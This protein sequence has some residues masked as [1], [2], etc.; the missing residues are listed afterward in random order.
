MNRRSDPE[1]TLNLDNT[2]RQQTLTMIPDGPTGT[3]VQVQVTGRTQD[4][5]D[6]VFSTLDLFAA[7]QK[8]CSHQVTGKQLLQD[9]LITSWP[10]KRT[11]PA[12][13]HH[14][15]SPDFGL[16]TAGTQHTAGMSGHGLHFAINGCDSVHMP[17][18]DII[19]RV[20]CTESI[21][22]GEHDVHIRSDHIGDQGTQGVVIT[23]TQFLDG[24]SVVFID[25]RH[26][27]ELEQCQD[28]IADIKIP[29]S[30]GKISMG[31]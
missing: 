14:F 13:S 29:V 16:H 17:G 18:R 22:I 28:S 20:C 3:T 30:V 11:S 19:N 8:K 4:I 7:G 2:G 6:P 9:F 21:H 25:N 15:C 23:K 24:N 27:P 26:N 10:D 1:S 31:E 12:G 5:G